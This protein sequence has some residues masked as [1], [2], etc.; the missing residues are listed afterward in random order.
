MTSNKYKM[1]KRKIN[2][3]INM[4]RMIMTMRNQPMVQMHIRSQMNKKF[5]KIQSLCS[6]NLSIRENIF[7]VASILKLN[8][9]IKTNKRNQ[10]NI[11]MNKHK[12]RRNFLIKSNY[13][14]N[15][16]SK[17]K[18][19]NHHHHNKNK[20]QWIL[21]KM[22]HCNKSNSKN[23]FLLLLK[24]ILLI[25]YKINNQIQIYNKSL[26]SNKMQLTVLLF[27]N[28]SIKALIN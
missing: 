1:K 15:N 25:M 22:F 20:C 17:F 28:E 19:N 11:F 9:K 24:S 4:K 6:F 21:L 23:Q 7:Q 10:K 2:I 8:L 12:F 26:K 16:N 18:N 27:S 14:N 5:Y 13:N 3:I